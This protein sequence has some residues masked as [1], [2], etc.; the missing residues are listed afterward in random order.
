MRKLICI[1]DDE[2]EL[3]TNL[4]LELASLQPD[5]KILT[6]PDGLKACRKS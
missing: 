2:D 5:W 6:F 1:V 3:V 4:K